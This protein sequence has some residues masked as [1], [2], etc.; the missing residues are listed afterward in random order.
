FNPFL[1]GVAVVN[2]SSPSISVLCFIFIN[3]PS[4]ASLPL[5]NHAIFFLVFLSSFNPELPSPSYEYLYEGEF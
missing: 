5:Y 1:Y 2:E 4:I 3:T